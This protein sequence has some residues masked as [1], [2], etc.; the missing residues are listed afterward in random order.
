VAANNKFPSDFYVTCATVIPV[1]FLAVAVQ[2]RTWE[3]ML[4]SYRTADQV[5]SEDFARKWRGARS[6]RE[7]AKVVFVGRGSANF[8]SSNLTLAILYVIAAGTFGE[9]MALLTLYRGSEVRGGR[10]IVFVATL[11]LVAAVAAGPIR[12][13]YLLPQPP[14]PGEAEAANNQLGKPGPGNG[15]GAPGGERDADARLKRSST[16]RDGQGPGN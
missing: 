10:F 1:L 16:S 11:I 9:F 3:S 13:A 6:W 2:G 5:A 15:T 8:K 4:R 7:R 14:A 12:A